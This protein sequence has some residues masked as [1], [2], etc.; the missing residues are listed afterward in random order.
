MARIALVTGAA[1][2]VGSTSVRAFAASGEFDFVVGVDNDQ[3][4]I[5]FGASASTLSVQHE[6]E[7]E[8]GAK[9][10]HKSIDIRDLDGM[11]AIFA[12]FGSDILCVLH[13]AAQPSHD[14]AAKEPL[15][16]FGVNAT[17]TVQLLE[18][19]RQHAPQ[20]VFM[21]TS[22][23]KVYGDLPNAMPVIDRGLRFDLPGGHP[24]FEGIDETMPL[25]PALHSVFGASKV[26]ADVMVQEYGQYFGMRTAVFRGG[27]LTGGA[28][29][30]AK[31]HG[32]LSYLVR[33]AATDTP[34]TI[35]GYG[36]KQVRDNIHASDLAAAFLC[37]FRKPSSGAVYNIGGGRMSNCSVLEAVQACE[38]KTGRQMQ[39]HFEEGPR[40]GDHRWYISDMTRFRTDFPDWQQ[41]WT[42]DAIL[43]QIFDAW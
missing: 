39:I 33:C 7:A 34:Y 29:K 40:R 10:L 4:A 11:Q 42:L 12:E 41:V 14:W 27:C 20:A 5:F 43:D 8:L 19:T 36:G 35:I 26:A 15:T 16:D 6:L 23:N 18:L 37:F 13:A 22:T 25:S 31:L 21:F 30:G 2:L 32:F 28:H 17:A 3:R 24:Q 1:G 9:Y 38:R